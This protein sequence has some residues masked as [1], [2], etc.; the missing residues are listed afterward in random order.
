M[1]DVVQISYNEEQ[2]DENF[3]ILQMFA[4]DAKR[5]IGVKGI[6]NAHQA[7]A[8]I[9]ETNHFYVID[10]D[11]V[12]DEE[13]SFKFRPD[14]NK[15]EYEYISQTECVYTWRS[16]NPVND[17][18]YGYGGAKLFPRKAL[19]QAKAWNVDMTTTIGCVFVPKFQVS[20]ITGFNTNPFETWK[21][22]FRE[23]AKLSSS[24]IPNGDNIDNE[25]RLDVWCSRGRDRPFGEY[26]L[27]GA[28][29]GKDFGIHYKNDMKSLTKINDFDWLNEQFALAMREE[30]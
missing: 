5:I 1:L 8:E 17:L 29:Q 14:P 23:C 22:A 28:N 12:M 10:A 25:Y 4:P 27:L 16:R 21:S 15:K 7:A 11:A 9:A 19:L 2:A 24:V 30:V 18:V 26:S 3:E 13:F 20:N 6:F